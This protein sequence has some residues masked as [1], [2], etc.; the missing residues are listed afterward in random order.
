MGFA[1]FMSGAAGRL[2][3]LA[4]GIALIA[5][6][7]AMR[8]VG[9]VAIAA[10]GVLPLAAGIFDICIFRPLFGASVRGQDLGREISFER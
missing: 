6:G 2:L 8:S 3:R 10:F 5:G 9:G 7:Y 1:R 4:A